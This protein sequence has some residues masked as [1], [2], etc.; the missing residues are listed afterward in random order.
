VQDVVI[1]FVKHQ[2][3]VV[4]QCAIACVNAV[5]FVLI[6]KAARIVK[7]VVKNVVKKYFVQLHSA[8]VF[9]YQFL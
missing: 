2:A 4:I 7:Y 6:I 9:S 1:H 5:I 3:N 8:F